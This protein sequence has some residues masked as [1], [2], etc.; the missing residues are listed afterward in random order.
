ML[1]DIGINKVLLD[2]SLL[3]ADTAF[4][5]IFYQIFVLLE[6]ECYYCY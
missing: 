1:L 3:K 2:L 6:K 4:I 5:V